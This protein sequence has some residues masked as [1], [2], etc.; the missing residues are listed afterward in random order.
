M[1]EQLC[2]RTKELRC[3]ALFRWYEAQIIRNHSNCVVF[4]RSTDT[5][6]R[7]INRSTIFLVNRSNNSDLFEAHCQNLHSV[8]FCSLVH[9]HIE[10]CSC[11]TNCISKVKK[12]ID[13]RPYELHPKRYNR[14]NSL[15]FPTN[16]KSLLLLFQ[17]HLI[18]CWSSS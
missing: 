11:R 6:Y 4:P 8:L 14:H 15:E 16:N 7:L 17:K 12:C 2:T 13:E 3:V 1:Y 9:S 10:Y 18:E 5:V